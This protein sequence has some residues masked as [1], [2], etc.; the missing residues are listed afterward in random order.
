MESG[1]ERV[2]GGG[3]RGGEE[4]VEVAVELKSC[5]TG[6]ELVTAAGGVNR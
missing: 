1:I 5:S 4:V 6:L 3:G 2:R